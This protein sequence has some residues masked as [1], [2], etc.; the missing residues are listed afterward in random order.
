[1]D[2]KILL[3]ELLCYEKNLCDIYMHGT[4]ESS[5]ENM[6][7]QFLENLNETLNN[8]HE[9]YKIMEKEGYYKIE[10]A[11]CEDIKKAQQKFQTN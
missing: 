3:E 6:F 8:Q 1:M 2:D 5:N 10:Q 11:K 7:N 4:I 9:V